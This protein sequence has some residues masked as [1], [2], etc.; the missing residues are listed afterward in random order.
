MT[1]V[2]ARPDTRS[3]GR[4]RSAT[5]TPPFRALPVTTR[6]FIDRTGVRWAV[7][8]VPPAPSPTEHRERRSQLRSVIRAFRKAERLSTRPLALATL[9][10]ER[11][12]ERHTERRRLTPAP[13]GWHTLPD[14]LLEDLLNQT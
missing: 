13:T 6:S 7:S 1:Q 8:E 2:S 9:L 12:T 14:D 5:P 4:A 10:F 3:A 11:A